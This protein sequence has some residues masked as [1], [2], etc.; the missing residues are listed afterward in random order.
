MSLEKTYHP[1]LCEESLY[2]MWEEGGYFTPKID[3]TKKPY[4]ILLPLPNA[5]DPMHMG[6]ALFSIQ[7]I[8]TRYHRMKGDPTLWLPGGDHAGIETQFVFE[9]HLAKEGKSRFDFDRCALYKMIWDYTQKYKDINKDQ[10]RRLGFS[11]DWTRYHYSL[12]PKIVEKVFET[13]KQLFKDGLIYR[14]ERLVNYCPKCGTSFSD[15]EIDHEEKDAFLYYLDYGTI[16]IATTRPETIFADTAVAVNPKDKRYKDVIGKEATIPLIKREIP[17]I[18]DSAIKI[19][20]GTGALKVTPAHDSADF[21]IGQRHSLGAVS[22]I[23]R[24]GR[25]INVPKKYLGLKV[26]SAREMVIVDLKEAGVLVKIVP[27]KHIVST[28]YR[29]KSL[30]EPTLSPQWYLK[31]KPLATKVIDAIKT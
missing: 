14:G 17:I 25:L 9:K 10:M 30:I 27:L 13:F 23:D 28:C 5:S 3:K 31:T 20:F 1:E 7:D 18:G 4:S 8:L 26:L 16:Q 24:S 29:C 12:E 2:K 21:E 6:H 22:C 11:L 15:L 19:D